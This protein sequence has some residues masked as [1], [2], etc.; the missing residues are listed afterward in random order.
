MISGEFGRATSMHPNLRD[1]KTTQQLLADRVAVLILRSS[2][3][4]SDAAAATAWGSVGIRGFLR[5]DD[6][7]GGIGHVEELRPAPR[8]WTRCIEVSSQ[9][10]TYY[11]HESTGEARAEEPRNGGGL[12]A[13]AAEID[14][15]VAAKKS[16]SSVRR[17]LSANER[18]E[19]T[20]DANKRRVQE[21]QD[22]RVR[23]AGKKGF[24]AIYS[25]E[26]TWADYEPPTNTSL[27]APS[28]RHG[29]GQYDGGAGFLQD[30]G[31][32]P[33][34]HGG[35]GAVDYSGYSG[36]SGCAQS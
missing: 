25:D 36:E 32:Y 2:A 18:Y 11:L 19:R 30:S 21:E 23:A 4:Y 22:Q 8:G 16:A 17:G 33:D 28:Y 7:D 35:G 26:T 24:A 1:Q 10:R 27:A 6:T 29:N 20:L 13:R 31:L 5:P 3:T 34:T 12:G 14:E 15:W 9:T